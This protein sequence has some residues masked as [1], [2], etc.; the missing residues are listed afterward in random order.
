MNLLFVCDHCSTSACDLYLKSQ[1]RFQ[2]RKEQSFVQ[3][4]LKFEGSRQQD[5]ITG[6][7]VRDLVTTFE[8]P[9]AGVREQGSASALD[10]ILTRNFLEEQSLVGSDWNM[11]L[12]TT[13]LP[14][15]CLTL[16]FLLSLP[17]AA[18]RESSWQINRFVHSQNYTGICQ[19]NLLSPCI[20]S[21][22]SFSFTIIN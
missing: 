14:L 17:T 1:K 9:F 8:R 6:D 16:S 4:L 7:F 22:T 15:L 2:F 10:I 18:V 12:W 5:A 21:I 19:N 3:V 20:H 11:R 13:P